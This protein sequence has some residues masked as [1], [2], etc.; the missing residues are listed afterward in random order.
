MSRGAAGRDGT[1]RGREGARR[2]HNSW[3]GVG[4][5]ARRGWAGQGSIPAGLRHGAAPGAAGRRG[6]APLLAGPGC[7]PVRLR[8][9]VSVRCRSR[10]GR[11]CPGAPLSRRP[12]L[13]EELAAGSGVGSARGRALYLLCRA[14]ALGSLSRRCS[15]GAG[16]LSAGAGCLRAPLSAAF[17]SGCWA[18]GSL[19]S[20]CCCLEL[21]FSVLAVW[22]V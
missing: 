21:R 20:C 4:R 1:G 11:R 14:R 15:A 7:V 6:W 3:G 2:Q 9:R 17:L 18:N 8:R 5:G 10:R 13:R 22:P 19:K 12:R 16:A